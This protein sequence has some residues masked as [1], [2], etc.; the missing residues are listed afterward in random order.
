[1]SSSKTPGYSK[2][3]R[4]HAASDQRTVK[5]IIIYASGSWRVSRI[6]LLAKI[7]IEHSAITWFGLLT[8]FKNKLFAMWL[9]QMD[10][11]YS[12]NEAVGFR[13]LHV[14]DTKFEE[15]PR[16]DS[17]NHWWLS[18]FHFKCTLVNQ[19]IHV[20]WTAWNQA[21]LRRLMCTFVEQIIVDELH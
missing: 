19:P 12:T 16:N 9:A 21:I 3:T 17:T 11:I 10:L 20:R 13:K 14:G 7:H 15:N 6:E 2:V 4:W 18:L 5:Y 8:E 1:M